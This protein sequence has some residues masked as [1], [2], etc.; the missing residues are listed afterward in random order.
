M[1]ELEFQTLYRD[2]AAAVRARCRAVCGNHA[3]AD[4]ALQETFLRAWRA[5]D[6]FD[7]RHPLAWLMTIARNTSLDIIR[8]R[9]PWRDDPL[10]WLKIPAPEK[11]SAGAAVDVN[12]MLEDIDAEDAAMLRLRHAEDWRIHEIAEHFDTSQ[13]TVRRRLAAAESRARTLLQAGGA[14]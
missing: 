9:R 12:R 7:G 3:D 1:T 5:R 2:T 4:E 13:R 10:V 14:A 8:R 6:R 11:A